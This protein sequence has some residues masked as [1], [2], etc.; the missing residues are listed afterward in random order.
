MKIKIAW[1][2]LGIFLAFSNAYAEEGKTTEAEAR[3]VWCDE[4]RLKCFSR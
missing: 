1:L 3:K 4:A 2:S